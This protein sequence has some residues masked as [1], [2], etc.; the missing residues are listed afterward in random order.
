MK[1]KDKPKT[2]R[3]QFP[4]VQAALKYME[5]AAG[6]GG[7][8]EDRR[9]VGAFVRLPSWEACEAAVRGGWPEG[10]QAVRPLVEGL[11]KEVGKG[12]LKDEYMPA[13]QGLFFDMG[14]V[15]SGEPECWLQTE[16]TEQECSGARIITLAVN[17]TVSGSIS[18][19]TIIQR[20][21]AVLGLAM[22][23]ERAGRAVRVVVGDA[24]TKD[25]YTLYSEIIVK[26]AGQ[27][28]D[29]DSLA[30]WLVCPDALRRCF[31]RICEAS[32]IA[33]EIGCYAG[34]GYGCPV[35]G[36]TP[37]GDITLKGIYSNSGWNPS[38]TREW[39]RGQLEAQ[40][41]RMQG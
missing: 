24:T 4:D 9:G 21:A 19:D 40:G 11:E 3:L 27:P 16:Q 41:V 7:C 28:F 13:T 37:E 5:P 22:L 35:E 10:V 39:I 15:L 25:G 2:M 20:G 34:G 38:K 32:P 8:S 18:S 30:F 33:K 29:V 26:E 1:D 14:L 17:T 36:W 12:V 6:K 23:L 31:F